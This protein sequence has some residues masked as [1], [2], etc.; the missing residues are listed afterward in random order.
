MSIDTGK[1]ISINERNVFIEFIHEHID[2]LP[3]NAKK[4][5]LT[6]LKNQIDDMKIKHKG[7][8]TQIQYKDISNDL[9]IW[10]YNKINSVIN[11]N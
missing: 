10:I 1:K 3:F 2:E 7:I 6:T 8:G 11:P 9:V 5:I 4:D